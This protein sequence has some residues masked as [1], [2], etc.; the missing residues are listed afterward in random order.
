MKKRASLNA[1]L[2]ILIILSSIFNWIPNAQAAP[3][4]TQALVRLDRMQ[5]GAATTGT[6][7]ARPTTTA[8]EG[9]VRITFPAGFTVGLT[10][11]WTTGV[12]TTGW[13][14]SPTPSAWPTIQATGTS[15]GQVVTFTGGDLT[16]GTTYCFNWTLTT[17]VTNASAANNMIGSLETLTSGL[18]TI[19]KSSIAFS[20]ITADTISVTGAVDPTFSFALP[21]NTDNFTTVLS[22]GATSTTTGSTA[23][24]TTNARNGWTTWVKSANAGL[25][26]AS[27]G[28]TTIT[29][30]GTYDGTPTTLSAGTTGYVMKV[31]TSGATAAPAAEYTSPGADQGGTLLNSFQIAA[32]G[33]AAAAAD[34]VTFTERARVSTTQAAAGDYTDTLTVI[35]AGQF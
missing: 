30:P 35:A 31:A 17:A 16:V 34:T 27:P 11:T 29:S 23:T 8:T 18:V 12:V 9:A 13:P 32:T 7:C 22:N 4:L 25:V 14:G 6:V 15:S 19:D 2:L 24:I 21:T 5:G 3:N 28:A 20:T 1:G 10:A 26:S 33:T